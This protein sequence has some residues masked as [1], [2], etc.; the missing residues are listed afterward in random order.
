MLSDIIKAFENRNPGVASFETFA[1]ECLAGMKSDPAN[2]SLYLL[3]GLTARQFYD[4]F[5]DQPLTVER[6]NDTRKRMVALSAE[7]AE[8]L[9][10]ANAS[11]SHVPASLSALPAEKRRDPGFLIGNMLPV[12]ISDDIAAA[13]PFHG[14]TSRRA[15]TRRRSSSENLVRW[16]S[17]AVSAR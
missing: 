15:T 13:K 12:C 4:Q 2:A 6:A 17:G 11:L 9:I 5:S 7:I 3:L 16:C 14:P 10:F 8:G 1:A